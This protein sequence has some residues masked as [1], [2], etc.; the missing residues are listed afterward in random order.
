MNKDKFEKWHNNNF[1]WLNDLPDTDDWAYEIWKAG[2]ASM[3]DAEPVYLVWYENCGWSKV[4]KVMFD[5]EE[6]ASNKWILYESPQPDQTA[7][8]TELQESELVLANN[9]TKMHE[10]LAELQKQNDVMREALSD[11][12]EFYLDT[13]CYT[14]KQMAETITKLLEECK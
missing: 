3:S 5:K 9:V 4:G 11:V 1:K 2:I 14:H 8:I 7:K 10:E 12:L 13:S 6:I